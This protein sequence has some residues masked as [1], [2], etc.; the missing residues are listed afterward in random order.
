M[1][2]YSKSR[3]LFYIYFILTFFFFGYVKEVLFVELA[4][5]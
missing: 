5:K 2:N 4:V 1:Q 3:K